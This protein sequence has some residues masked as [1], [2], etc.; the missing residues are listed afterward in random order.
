MDLRGGSFG[1][2]EEEV[3]LFCLQREISLV[4]GPLENCT[5]L[6]V[7]RPCPG[8][9]QKDK[10]NDRLGFIIPRLLAQSVLCGCSWG[11]PSC[12][13]RGPVCLFPSV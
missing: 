11:G 13:F 3:S 9:E 1:T 10:S 7:S 8:S 4:D 12:V 6:G 5:P 2:G